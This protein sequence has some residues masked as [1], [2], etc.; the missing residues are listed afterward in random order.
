MPLSFTKIYSVTSNGQTEYYYEFGG[1]MSGTVRSYLEEY[2]LVNIEQ[3]DENKNNVLYN[4]KKNL[5]VVEF[6]YIKCVD[7]FC[8]LI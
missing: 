7:I 2:D 3:E 8:H 6:F 1:N 5:R 4:M